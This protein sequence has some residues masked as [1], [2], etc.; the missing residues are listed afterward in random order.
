M[1]KLNF[2][3]WKLE[4]RVIQTDRNLKF[5]FLGFYLTCFKIKFGQLR[6]Y[7]VKFKNAMLRGDINGEV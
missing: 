5:S 3:F 2:A 6:Y 1:G 4:Y 7:G